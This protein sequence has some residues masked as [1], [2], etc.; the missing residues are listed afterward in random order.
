[1]EQYRKNIISEMAKLLSEYDYNYTQD[2]LKTIEAEWHYNKSSLLALFE[3]HPNYN[4][5]GQ[6]VLTQEYN[7]NQVT[8]PL[9]EMYKELIHVFVNTE[10]PLYKNNEIISKLLNEHY[11]KTVNVLG[12]KSQ[13]IDEQDIELNQFLPNKLQMSVGQKRSRFVSKF[14]AYF[15]LDELIPEYNKKFAQYADAINPLK[16]KRWTILSINP[17]DYLTM[18][19]GNSWASCH[20]ID[21]NNKRNMPN[22]YSGAYSAGT[23]SYM[24]DKTSIVVYTI[25]SK[26]NGENFELEP[27]INRC[28]FHYN[29]GILIQGRVYPQCNDSDSELINNFRNV[30]QKVIADCEKVS[31]LWTLKKGIKNVREYADTDYKSV[32]YRDYEHFDTCTVSLI[33][34]FLNNNDDINDVVDIGHAPISV[35]TG[36]EHDVKN[37]IEGDNAIYCADCGCIIDTES[38]AYSIDD[39]GNYY[40]TDCSRW[41]EYHQQFEPNIN[42]I[43]IYVVNYGLVCENALIT[44]GDFGYCDICEEYHYID[45]LEYLENYEIEV[46]N[47]CLFDNYT[48]DEKTGMYIDNDELDTEAI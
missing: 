22:T 19:F 38:E 3:K 43:F 29:N 14:C 1:M 5:R 48:Y 39:N 26:F 12:S 45:N 40:C 15:G 24:L 17:I 6:I 13:F 25:D 37:N 44:S 32:H 2:A 4:G 10:F 7:R 35:V 18:S 46:C 20:T 34:E 33:K 41:C 23:I 30:V 31:N 8:K 28:M 27:K 21:K 16:I 36:N 9:D 42:N 11:S 47:N